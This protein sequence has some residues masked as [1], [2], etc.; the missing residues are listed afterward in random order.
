MQ[1]TQTVTKETKGKEFIALPDLTTKDVAKYP[2][3]PVRFLRTVN[4]TGIR[5]GSITVTLD[6]LNLKL[7][8]TSTERQN[9]KNRRLK[10]LQVEDFASIINKLDLPDQKDGKQVNEWIKN[11]PIRFAKGTFQTEDGEVEWHSVEVIFNRDVKRAIFLTKTQLELLELRAKK[12]AIIDKNKKPI[13][14]EWV[15]YPE[16]IDEVEDIADDLVF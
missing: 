15:T 6:P 8:V 7:S 11:A 12:N 13:K 14:I 9:G 10:F 5:A 2:V 3:V 16:A 1:E 4:E